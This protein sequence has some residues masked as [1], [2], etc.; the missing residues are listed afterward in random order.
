MLCANNLAEQLDL[1][2][3]PDATSRSSEP[4]KLLFEEGLLPTHEQESKEYSGTSRHQ[5]LLTACFRYAPRVFREFEAENEAILASRTP[6]SAVHGAQPRSPVP[7]LPLRVCKFGRQTGAET[8]RHNAC[9]SSI[10]EFGQIEVEAFRRH[11]NDGHNESSISVPAVLAPPIAPAP[12]PNTRGPPVQPILSP[13]PALVPQDLDALYDAALADVDLDSLLAAATAAV[14]APTD[15]KA[16]PWQ[17]SAIAQPYNGAPAALP[18]YPIAAA[19][20]GGQATSDHSAPRFEVE[21]LVGRASNN[22]AYPM[23]SGG[24]LA[25]RQLKDPSAEM[26]R[27]FGHRGFRPGQVRTLDANKWAALTTDGWEV[28]AVGPTI[29]WC[30][31]AAFN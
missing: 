8:A 2:R 9:L 11:W 29:A 30:L 7:T 6:V 18:T 21:E 4:H 20:Y 14:S 16:R 28:L 24:S 15:G 17:G 27:L 10:T 3:L 12:L 1:L 22:L 26:L 5:D 23:R 25:P 19:P 31:L 13:R